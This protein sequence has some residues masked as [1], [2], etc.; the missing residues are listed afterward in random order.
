[1]PAV[2]EANE[3]PENNGQKCAQRVQAVCTAGDDNNHGR[4][5]EGGDNDDGR[6]RWKLPTGSLTHV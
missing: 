6:A 1:M 4:H 2:L 3:Q 5:P